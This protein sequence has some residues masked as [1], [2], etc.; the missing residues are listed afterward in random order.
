MRSIR[1]SELLA[2][3]EHGQRLSPARRALALLATTEPETPIDDLARLSIGARDARLLALRE[4]LFGPR[5]EGRTTCAGCGKPLAVDFRT[6]D[7]RRRPVMPA[8]NAGMVQHDGYEVR[9]RL[10][11]STDLLSI[12]EEGDAG[13]ALSALRERCVLGAAAGGESRPAFGLPPAVA[14]ALEERMACLDPDADIQL[15]LRC[16]DCGHGWEARFD[17]VSFLWTELDAWARRLLGQVHELAAA[18]GWRE[19]DI[20]ALS[21]LRRQLYL[22]LVRG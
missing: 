15:A 1:A 8:Q 21:P 11:D 20:L 7:I 4:V 5:L 12:A 14:A 18:Y 13:S 10:P 2:V 19:G 6:P 17:I 9:F 16:P 3:W 22:G